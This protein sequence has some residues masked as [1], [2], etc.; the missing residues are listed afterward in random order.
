MFQQPFEERYNDL[1]KQRVA[2]EGQLALERQQ[3]DTEQAK[4]LTK[5]KRL[6]LL[7]FLLP[8]LTF[9]YSKKKYIT[10]LEQKAV[11]QQDAILKL[12]AEIAT[13]KKVKKDSVHYIIS[14]GDMLVTL[15]NL[16]FNDP[17]EGYQIGLDN[18]ITTDSQRY[19]LVLGDTLTIHYR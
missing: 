19:N 3:H 7:L 9:W 6:L 11:T 15:G 10:P 16:F 1:L 4:M 13:L 14:K 8:L 12:N 5:N 18:G 2:L 17:A